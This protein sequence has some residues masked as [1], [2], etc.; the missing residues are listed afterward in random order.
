MISEEVK[1]VL[2]GE[3]CNPKLDARMGDMLLRSILNC[4]ISAYINLIN[5]RTGVIC[6]D[7]YEK[8]H[9]HNNEQGLGL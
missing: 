1:R 5:L 7:Y 8:L 9:Q 2:N 6:D 3:Y 4:D